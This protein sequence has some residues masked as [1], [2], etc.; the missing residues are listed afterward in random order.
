M[1]AAAGIAGLAE[2][3]PGFALVLARVTAFVVTMPILGGPYAPGQVKVLLGVALAACA[4]PGAM[5]QQAQPVVPDARFVLL[6]GQEVVIGL[7]L[8]W[9][10]GL[11]AQGV[12]M[13]GELISRYAGFTAAENFDPEAD[14]GSGPFA[15]LL[16]IA[17]VM[18]F[19]ATDTHHHLIAGVVRSYEAVPLG[20]AALRPEVAGMAA[21][22]VQQ[23][24][25]VACALA[26]PVLAV[27]MA[28]TVL[29]GVLTRAVPQINVLHL[30]FTVK[31]ILSVV[32]TIVGLPAIIAFLHAVLVAMQ[33]LLAPALRAFA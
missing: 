9:L 5:A 32:V 14:V 15:D 31:I 20:A 21:A 4:Y 8:G 18:L 24:M 25:V 11:L 19:F 33:G 2:Q 22:G 13:G 27:V 3:L 26:F 10:L 1:D 7:C 30:S 6:L 12:R 28:V 16:F 29:E 17:L 23:S